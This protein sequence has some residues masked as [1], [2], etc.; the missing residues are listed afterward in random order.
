MNPLSASIRAHARYARSANLERDGDGGAIAD[1]LPTARSLDLLRRVTMACLES[2]R[3]RAWSVTGPYG[4][5]KSSFALLLD[6]LLGPRGGLRS[7]SISLIDSADPELANL[8]LRAHQHV[9]TE[10]RGFIRAVVT[11]DPEPVTASVL[12]ATQRGVQRYWSRGRKPSC[13]RDIARALAA[14]EGGD[15][16]EPVE[17]VG[18]MRSLAAHAPVLLVLDEFGKNLEYLGQSAANGDQFYVLQAI[19]EASSGSAGV[20]LFLMTLQHMS[21][22]D[23]FEGGATRQR[24]EW[25][26]VQGRF[27]DVVYIDS[28]A[29]TVR[30]MSQVFESIGSEASTRRVQDWATKAWAAVGRVGIADLVGDE[31]VLARTYPLHP[32]TVATLPELCRRYGQNERTLFGFLTHDEPHAVGEFLAARS[33]DDAGGLPVVRLA[34]VFDYFVGS[35]SPSLGVSPAARRWFEIHE[36]ITQ[37]LGLSLDEIAV[38][39][40]IGVLNLVAQGGALRASPDLLTYALGDGSGAGRRQAVKVLLRGLE[41]RGFVNYRSFADEYRVWEGSDFDLDGQLGALQGAFQNIPIGE[42]IDQL[43]PLSP[44]VASRHSQQRGIVRVFRRLVRETLDDALDAQTDPNID[45]VI[46]HVTSVGSSAGPRDLGAGQVPVVA[47]E[48]PGLEDLRAPLVAA[49]AAQQLL[50]GGD[51]LDWVARKELSERAAVASA[52][53]RF[54]ASELLDR[55]ENA[56]LLGSKGPEHLPA[57]RSVSELASAAC[58]L[59]YP[60]APIVA[61][62]MLGRGTLTSQ[63]ARARLDLLTAMVAATGRPRLGIDGYGPERAMYEAVLAREGIHRELDGRWEF[64][65][66]T[67]GSYS[68]T[69]RRM[70]EVVRASVA[71]RLS[72]GDL[73][74]MLRRP[75]LGIKPP[76]IPVLLTAYLLANPDQVAVYQDAVFQP[77]LTPELLERLTKAP[78]RFEVRYLAVEGARVAALR[79]VATEF[80]LTLRSSSR[81]RAV[82]V[83]SVVAPLLDTV[84]RLPEYALRSAHMSEA[85]ERVREA[86]LSAREPDQLLFDDLPTALGH[87]PIRADRPADPLA[88]AAALHAALAELEGAYPKL[89]DEISGTVSRGLALDARNSLK[90]ESAARARPLLTQVVEPRLRSLL[91]ALSGDTLD[92]NDW[93]EAVGLALGERPPRTWAATDLDRFRANAASMLGAFRRV[94]ALHFDSRAQSPAGFVP[95]KVTITAP[96]G[97]EFSRVVYVDEATRPLLRRI[98][99]ETRSKV[100]RALPQAGEEALLAAL[101]DEVLGAPVED[102]TDEVE[103]DA[104]WKLT[105]VQG[106]SNGR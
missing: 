47:V 102:H 49:A 98:V 89:L 50:A 71:G 69:W 93:L 54:A 76:M 91:F 34:Q 32:I 40:A 103:A 48:T 16:V 94:E 29:Q 14:V 15:Q 101:A 44:V 61:N 86:F 46:A 63:G 55:S 75:P 53:A 23:Y 77:T 11:A 17:V 30:L 82:P 84:R 24:R 27:E 88:F 72:V 35:V 10:A 41:E 67:A 7:A 4:S 74:A 28:P 33:F 45:G 39:K 106:S 100:A 95:R 22:D 37:F 13:A 90:I 85:A 99:R 6:G 97:T 60:L 57:A 8:V 25:A 56:V 31:S 42:L 79:A 26:K 64:G 104:D 70:D 68:A 18:L 59:A 58:D 51:H 87:R 5:G 38:L 19:A 65:E 80:G 66:P 36:R 43:L 2:G 92:D 81:H 62:E 12:R 96:D 73:E 21:F 9:S 83:L 52:Q 1:F 105:R 3:P 20:P 78:D